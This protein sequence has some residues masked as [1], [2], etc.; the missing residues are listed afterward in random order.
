MRKEVLRRKSPFCSNLLSSLSHEI[1]ILES[2]FIEGRPTQP[3][4]AFDY[5]IMLVVPLFLDLPIPLH[6]LMNPK[7]LSFLECLLLREVTRHTGTSRSFALAVRFGPRVNR[8]PGGKVLSSLKILSS[9][10]FEF[11]SD[12]AESLSIAG[13]QY[14]P[15]EDMP[16]IIGPPLMIPGFLK[17]FLEQL[18]KEE[19]LGD[20]SVEHLANSLHS[21]VCDVGLVKLLT[22]RELEGRDERKRLPLTD[23]DDARVDLIQ[24][25]AQPPYA[26]RPLVDPSSI[27]VH[28][29]ALPSR[30]FLY[31]SVLDLVNALRERRMVKVCWNCGK[32]YRP[33][34]Y[35]KEGQHYCSRTCRVRAQ[36][37]RYY[38]RSKDKGK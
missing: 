17:P 33:Y 24:D 10:D 23:E 12:I 32:L 14:P 2:Y 31:G 18:E 5:K 22:I 29:D 20:E 30:F 28:W 37:R 27:Q 25:V 34:Q 4:K 3:E 9:K 35:Q 38:Q 26:T 6:R 11:T 36:S 16:A 7:E 19:A 13:P 8:A 21:V 1:E 15:F